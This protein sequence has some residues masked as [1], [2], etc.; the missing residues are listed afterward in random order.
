MTSIKS[1][2]KEAMLRIG[3]RAGR[4]GAT[5][6]DLR[7]LTANAQAVNYIAPSDGFIT[8]SGKTISGEW[9]G[10]NAR[11]ID[12]YVIAGDSAAIYSWVARTMPVKKGDNILI[13][14]EGSSVFD[15]LGFIPSVGGG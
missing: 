4:A 14:R 7:G 9:G 6:I 15:T 12:D 11:T 2:L 5:L 8:F 10:L 1:D 13:R 3:S